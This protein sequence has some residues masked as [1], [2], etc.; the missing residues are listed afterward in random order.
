MIAQPV[1]KVS[2]RGNEF[3]LGTIMGLLLGGLTVLLLTQRFEAPES[4]QA[5]VVAQVVP[6]DT[7]T[8]TVAPTMTP[9]MDINVYVMP[10]LTPR[11]TSTSVNFCSFYDENPELATPGVKCRIPKGLE[12]PTATRTPVPCSAVKP[13]QTCSWQPNWSKEE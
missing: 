13:G 9:S 6:T 8:S 7:P 12:T 10:S 1:P 11:P 4:Y 3:L 5:P 2:D